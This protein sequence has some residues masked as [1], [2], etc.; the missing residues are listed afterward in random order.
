MIQLE[1]RRYFPP[2]ILLQSSFAEIFTHMPK[3]YQKAKPG[4]AKPTTIWP[5][6]VPSVEELMEQLGTTVFA[7]AV[8]HAVREYLRAVGIW[9]PEEEK[10]QTQ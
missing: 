10:K 6:L 1:L 3:P 7:H 5:D 2:L 8:N 4:T 9:K